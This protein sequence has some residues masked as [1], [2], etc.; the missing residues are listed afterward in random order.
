MAF[1]IYT[2]AP[3]K[4]ILY[5][6][7]GECYTVWSDICEF[8][9]GSVEKAL[10]YLLSKSK[11]HFISISS[12]S[13]FQTKCLCEQKIYWDILALICK[14]LDHTS[15]E[16]NWCS[17]FHG[18]VFKLPLRLLRRH[19][20]R[21]LL[22]NEIYWHLS[23]PRHL[24]ITTLDIPVCISTYNCFLFACL[25]LYKCFDTWDSL[26]LCLNSCEAMV[27]SS[28]RYIILKTCFVPPPFVRRQEAVGLL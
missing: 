15:S 5:P 19:N 4:K 25:L 3:W 9:F 28:F 14:F 26:P 1:E 20:T 8:Y 2:L 11:L 6:T 13:K 12:C 18:H 7:F 16:R 21:L 10:V 23:Y 24:N 17:D 27:I 22:R